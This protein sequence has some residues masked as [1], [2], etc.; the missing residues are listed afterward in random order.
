MAYI[1]N[2]ILSSQKKMKPWLYDNTDGPQGCYAKW[3]NSD[4]ERQRLY[5]LTYMIS[6]NIENSL[7]VARGRGEMGEGCLKVYIPSYKVNKSWECNAQ[8]GDYCW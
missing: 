6:K 8:H 5:D 4:T 3:N 2:G 7:V 1:H